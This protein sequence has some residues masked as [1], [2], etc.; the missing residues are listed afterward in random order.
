MKLRLPTQPTR[1]TQ[2]DVPVPEE[3]VDDINEEVKQYITE[4]KPA[5]EKS[6][7]D[8]INKPK[9]QPEK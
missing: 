9:L 1:V 7:K 4:N 3:P 2:K 6:D 8:S 5:Q